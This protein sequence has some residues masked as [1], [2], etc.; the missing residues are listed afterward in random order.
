MIV[1]NVQQGS[2]AWKQLR[3]GKVT[4]SRVADIM[5]KTK[6]G[7][8]ASRAN[9]LSEL[10]TERLTNQPYEQFTNAAM[11]WGTEQEP[12]ARSLYALVKDVDVETVGIVQHPDID[13]F[14][15]SPDGLVGDDGLIEIKCPNTS[16]ALDY[17]MTETIPQKYILQMTAQLM[18][19]GR[20]WCDFVSYDP[21][22]PSEMQLFVK[23]FHRPDDKVLSEYLDLIKV[24][25]VEVDTAVSELRSKYT[26]KE[27]PNNDNGR[28][29]QRAA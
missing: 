15:A 11:A 21:R 18:C 10:V 5:A 2:D 22:L 16:T 8:G 9:Y 12:N 13:E 6:T 19:S 29:G 23:R 24:F 3:L 25:L 17:L 1:H 28:T 26:K 14:L 4:A 7:W 20:S 27:Q